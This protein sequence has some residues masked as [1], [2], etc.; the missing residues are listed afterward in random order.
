V[1]KYGGAREATDDSIIWDMCFA[2][3]IMKATN[4]H[5]EYEIIIAFSQ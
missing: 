2:C 3:W 1:G 4:T 5:S